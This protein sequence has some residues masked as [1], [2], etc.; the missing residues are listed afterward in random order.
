MVTGQDSIDFMKGAF[1]KEEALKIKKRVV[2]T[3]IVEGEG[4]G[5]WQLVVDNGT[6]EFTSGDGITPVTATVTY[7]DAERSVTS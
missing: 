4:G 1:S 2:I 7:R 5:V 6:F 3:Y